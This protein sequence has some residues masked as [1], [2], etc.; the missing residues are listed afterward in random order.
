MTVWQL[1]CYLVH[2]HMLH[3]DMTSDYRKI[4]QDMIYVK[5]ISLTEWSI[6]GI[7]YLI[8]LCIIALKADLIHSGLL[9]I[10][11]ITSKPKLAE[12]EVEVQL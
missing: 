10:W 12:P 2:T 7:L 11:Y 4:G 5:K 8:M 6:F 1:Q 9:K 3:E